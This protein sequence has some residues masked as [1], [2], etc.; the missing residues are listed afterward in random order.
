M[1][2]LSRTLVVLNLMFFVQGQAPAV[3]LSG[4]HATAAD[5]PPR[6]LSMA[7]NEGQLMVET[8]GPPF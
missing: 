5:E 7:I 1:F 2:P 8:L 4:A 3:A 6:R